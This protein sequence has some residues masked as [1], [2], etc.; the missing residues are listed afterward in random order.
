MEYIISKPAEGKKEN[1][2]NLGNLIKEME[3]KKEA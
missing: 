1:K 2:E 3:Y